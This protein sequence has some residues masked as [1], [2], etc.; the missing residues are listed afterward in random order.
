[1]NFAA[2]YLLNLAA[3]AMG[4]Q[5]RRPLLFSYYVTH[6]CPLECRYC[7]DGEGHPFKESPV[8]ELTTDQA[9]RLIDVLA[10]ACDT[11][12]VT[13]GEPMMRSDLESLLDH[14]RR[15]G[16]RTVLNIQGDRSS[17]TAGTDADRCF[18]SER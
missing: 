14:A 13:G 17:T 9:R 15:H 5:P 1:M 3:V 16:M 2:A 12:D 8:D 11:L 10:R 7:S 18:D 4:R 6:R